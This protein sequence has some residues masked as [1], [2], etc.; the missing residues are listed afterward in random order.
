MESPVLDAQVRDTLQKKNKQLR[1]RG[2]VP[3][4]LYGHGIQNQNLQLSHLQFGKFYGKAGESTLVDLKIDGKDPVKVLIHDVQFDPLTQEPMHVDFYQVRMDE[5]ITAKIPLH[6]VG[7]AA[8]VKDL[9]GTLVKNISELEVECLPADLISSLEVDISPLVDFEKDIRVKDLAIPKNLE[10]K[11][12]INDTV[13]LVEAPR[14]EEELKALDEQVVEDVTAVAA[15]KEEKKEAEDAEEGA[16][17]GSGTK[18]ES[19]KKQ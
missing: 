5:K 12:D 3:A 6:F 18:P 13:V 8:A 10:V 2:I 4:V 7:V 19:T 14:T 17:A 15:A 16:S 9:G 11:N 1:S